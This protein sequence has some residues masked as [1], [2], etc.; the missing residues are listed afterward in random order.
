MGI[1][2][3]YQKANVTKTEKVIYFVTLATFLISI[4]FVIGRLITAS[5]TGGDEV[6]DKV[7]ADYLLM[8]LQLT[9]G[10]VVIHIPSFVEKRI[11]IEIPSFM[12]IMFIVFLF[13]AIYLGEVKFFYYKIKSWDVILHFFSAVM[14][15]CLSFSV[16][17][18][19]SENKIE[20]IHPL[21]VA[22]FA[23]CFAI[24]IEVLWEFYEFC[25]DTFA[26]FNMQKY[27]TE[28]GVNLIGQLALLDTIEDLIIG[29]I[30]ALLASLLGFFSLKR[31]TAFIR[32]VILTKIPL[33]ETQNNDS[34]ENLDVNS[35]IN[36]DLN[37][38]DVTENTVEEIN[39]SK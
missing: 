15:G 2:K 37:A 6:T 33:V 5:E 30:G 13:C 29:S 11:K 8:L 35:E 24:T 39:D 17:N 25:W 18:A 3:Q 1:K 34:I 27:Q 26:G 28:E 32:K 12:N 9:A 7:T 14:L 22:I 31:K 20:G 4:I 21:F 10:I 16:I 36:T 23:F 38:K 19:L